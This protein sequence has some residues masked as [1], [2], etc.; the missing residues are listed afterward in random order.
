MAHLKL[1][2]TQWLQ[3]GKKLGH[4]DENGRMKVAQGGRSH[5]TVLME[6]F[7]ETDDFTIAKIMEDMPWTWWG[8]VEGSAALQKALEIKNKYEVSSHEAVKFMQKLRSYWN[9]PANI[10]TALSYMDRLSGWEIMDIP[11]AS[12]SYEYARSAGLS[13]EDISSITIPLMDKCTHGTISPQIANKETIKIK[14]GETTFEEVVQK[15]APK[16]E[17]KAPEEESP[18]AVPETQAAQPARSHRVKKGEPISMDLIYPKGHPRAGE[19]V[20]GGK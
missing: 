8:N 14:N 1:N 19:I 10:D 18:T 2:T 5:K 17:E 7:G 11:M 3:L 15:Y 12:Y 13:N 6:D 9:D 20:G 4:I 16:Q